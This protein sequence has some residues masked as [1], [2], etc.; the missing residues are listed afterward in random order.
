MSR[1]LHQ[2]LEELGMTYDEFLES[3]E[4]QDSVVV[5]I[6]RKSDC[7]YTTEVEPDCRN[8]WC[9]ECNS[10]TVVSILVL[11]GVI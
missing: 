2:C 6:C 1:K 4:A 5:G 3:S 7:D 11:M 8:G 10:N 9:E